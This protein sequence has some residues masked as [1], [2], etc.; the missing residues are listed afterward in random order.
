MEEAYVW[1][2]VIVPDVADAWVI[3]DCS[4]TAGYGVRQN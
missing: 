2:G 3:R 1:R 4:Y